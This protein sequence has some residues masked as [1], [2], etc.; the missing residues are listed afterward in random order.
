MRMLLFSTMLSIT[1]TL[2]KDGFIKLVIEWNQSSPHASNVISGI[3]WNGERNVTYSHE[4]L[5]LAIEEYRNENIIAIRYE[6]NEDGDVVYGLCD[7]F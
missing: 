4:N 2:T 7:E 5:S 1:D 3:E 6:K